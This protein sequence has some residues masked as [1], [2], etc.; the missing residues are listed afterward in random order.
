M[1]L[2]FEVWVGNS[3]SLLLTSPT[4]FSR[5]RESQSLECAGEEAGFSQ[6]SG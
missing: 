1:N 4:L 6:A 5:V 3:Y 2:D